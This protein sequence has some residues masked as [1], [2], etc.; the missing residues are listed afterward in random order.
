MCLRFRNQLLADLFLFPIS[1]PFEEVFKMQC[2]VTYVCGFIPLM[3]LYF[4]IF[5]V[6]LT[7]FP[8]DS[9][10]F[11]YFFFFFFKCHLPF[12]DDISAL[13]NNNKVTD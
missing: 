13:G 8:E 10:N 4:E 1:G 3:F 5:R 12:A 6:S 2:I 11:S 9:Q 7:L